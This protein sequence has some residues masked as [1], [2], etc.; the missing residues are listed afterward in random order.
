MDQATYD[1]LG[2]VSEDEEDNDP[3]WLKWLSDWLNGLGDDESYEDDGSS[4]TT[5]N[6]SKGLE[7]IIWLFFIGLGVYLLVKYRSQ[8]HDF[9][10]GLKA[11]NKPKEAL[12][13]TL[14]G[15]DVK[16]DSL[17]KD[18]VAMAQTAW[19]QGEQRQAIA[20]LLRASLIKLL[21]DHAC[22]FTDSDTEAE[23]CTRIDKQASATVATFMR[24]LVV[25]WQ[26][27]AYAHKAPT[28]ERFNE[29]CQQWKQVF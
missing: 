18:V 27:V 28:E 26:Q 17:P 7:I 29:L 12:P 9:I 2:P 14:F 10:K 1:K 19:R 8:L 3:K 13:A 16:K 4:D 22:H 24:A 11:T 5:L 20:V 23:C 15:L 21:H 25:V 6:I